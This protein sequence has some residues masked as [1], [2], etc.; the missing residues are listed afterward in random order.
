MEGSIK[1][2]RHGVYHFVLQGIENE[3]CI[4]TKFAL[5]MSYLGSDLGSWGTVDDHEK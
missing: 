5:V 2:Q 3:Y 4:Q 1:L